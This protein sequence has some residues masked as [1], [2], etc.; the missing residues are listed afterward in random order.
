[1][2]YGAANGPQ[3]D[4]DDYLGPCSRGVWTDSADS[5]DGVWGLGLG[6][7]WIGLIWWI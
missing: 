1:M 3:N 7:G 5:K 2:V 4:I 6:L